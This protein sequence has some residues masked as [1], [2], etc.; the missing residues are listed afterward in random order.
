M[1]LQRLFGDLVE[2]VLESF[3][4]DEAKDDCESGLMKMEHEVRLTS[5]KE[6]GLLN[7]NAIELRKEVERAR[8]KLRRITEER[9]ENSRKRVGL[10]QELKTIEMAE[11]RRNDVALETEKSLTE[12]KFEIS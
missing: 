6:G 5:K 9:E 8:Q 11:K 2:C 4:L 10:E 12:A 1:D 3:S 7:A